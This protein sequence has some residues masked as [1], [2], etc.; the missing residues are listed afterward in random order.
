MIAFLLQYGLLAFVQSFNL[1][2]LELVD[3]ES[4]V[5]GSRELDSEDSPFSVCL[6]MFPYRIKDSVIPIIS[7]RLETLDVEEGFD[8]DT[9]RF[10]EVWLIRNGGRMTNGDQPFKIQTVHY[11]FKNNG[12]MGQGLDRYPY[13]WYHMCFSFKKT[14]PGLGEQIYYANVYTNITLLEK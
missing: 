5:K 4:F 8:A 2:A 7:I 10:L 11:N 6:R 3:G 13:Q 9:N 12:D 1:G 14:G